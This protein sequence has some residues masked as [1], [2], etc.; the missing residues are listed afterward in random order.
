MMSKTFYICA[1]KVD[2]DFCVEVPSKY[3][4]EALSLFGRMQGWRKSPGVAERSL[5]IGSQMKGKKFGSKEEA[6][7]EFAMLAKT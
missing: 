7:N 6:Q 5:Y 1:G 2:K 3:Y 4:E